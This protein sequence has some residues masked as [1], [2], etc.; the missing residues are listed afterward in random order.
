MHEKNDQYEC[1][2]PRDKER[3]RKEEEEEE[4]K[5]GQD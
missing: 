1:N 3:R 2:I 4:E 5:V